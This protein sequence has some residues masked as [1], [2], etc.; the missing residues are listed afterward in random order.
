MKPEEQFELFFKLMDYVDK[1]RLWN[2]MP[3]CLKAFED[4]VKYAEDKNHSR[5]DLQLMCAKIK[6]GVKFDASI[7]RLIWA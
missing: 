4:V 6:E 2:S 7:M 3:F 5:T 1:V